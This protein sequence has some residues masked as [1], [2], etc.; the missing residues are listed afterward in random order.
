MIFSLVILSLIIFFFLWILFGPLDFV[1]NT[2]KEEYYFQLRKVFRISIIFDEDEIVFLN[3]R[4][5]VIGF[6]IHPLQILTNPKEKKKGGKKKKKKEK[7]KRLQRIRT[8]QNMGLF[9][10]RLTWRTARTF[11]LRKLKLNIDTNNV[12]A[13]A[14]LIPIFTILNGNRTQLSVNY[15]GQIGVHIVYENSVFLIL[16]AV[17]KSY[18]KHRKHKL[19]F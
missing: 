14:Y 10:L 6:N 8:L 16:R 2:F 3:I 9:A 15:S 18:L 12:V 5:F 13:N 19:K 1:A 7:R 4:V 11:K 17:I